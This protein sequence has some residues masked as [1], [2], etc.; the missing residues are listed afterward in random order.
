MVK[1]PHS[2]GEGIASSKAEKVVEMSKGWVRK[3][4]I[5]LVYNARGFF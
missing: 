2:L 4:V 3:I 1:D 5:V